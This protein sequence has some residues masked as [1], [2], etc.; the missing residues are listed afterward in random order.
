M[1]G[2]LSGDRIAV[3]EGHFITRGDLQNED[4]NCDYRFGTGA[5]ND[6]THPLSPFEMF[7]GARIYF[8]SVTQVSNATNVC[9]NKTEISCLISKIQRLFKLNVV[10]F[11]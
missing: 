2:E 7:L 6:P 10:Y 3:N 4:G 9:N 11:H 5:I 1:E 8:V